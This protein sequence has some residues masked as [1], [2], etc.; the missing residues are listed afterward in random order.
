MTIAQHHA[1]WL[2]LLEIFGPFA[3]LP[4]LRTLFQGL[5]AL[6]TE[7]RRDLR[8]GYEE[9]L[10]NQGGLQP[11]PAIHRAWAVCVLQRMKEGQ[12]S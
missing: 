4:V 12:N 2:C 7:L 10:D 8:V 1:E 11:E 3:R 6:D 5:D 9:W